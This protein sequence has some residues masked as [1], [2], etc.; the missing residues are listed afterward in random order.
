MQQRAVNQRFR[1]RALLVICAMGMC[2]EATQSFL[3]CDNYEPGIYSNGRLER[4]NKLPSA[5]FQ[6]IDRGL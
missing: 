2:L 5:M 4:F 6:Y 3:K 1:E